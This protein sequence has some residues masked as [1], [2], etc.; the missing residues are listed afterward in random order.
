MGLSYPAGM[1][2]PWILP[3]TLAGF[4]AEAEVIAVNGDDELRCAIASLKDGVTL[5]IKGGDYRGGWSVKGISQLTVEA[6][7]PANPPHFKNGNLAWQFSHCPGLTVRN[8]IVSGQRHNGFN[9]DD[10]GVRDKPIKGV[11]L[12]GLKV[13]EIG[14]KGNFDGI[15]CSGINDLVIKECEVS[16]WGGQAID[17]VGCHRAVISD[18]R[19]TGRP[20]FSQT[21]GPQFKGGS[22]DIVIERCFLRMPECGRSKPEAQPG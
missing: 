2:V 5:K 4:L 20:G 13:F 14:P 21:T 3:F 12:S 9:I 19:F 17:F 6:G 22:S 10:G 1:K 7:D 8:L 18:C 11:T 16:G 15:K